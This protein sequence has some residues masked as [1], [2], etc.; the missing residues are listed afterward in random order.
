VPVREKQGE[1]V[2]AVRNQ[3][4]MLSL[5]NQKQLSPKATVSKFCSNPTVMLAISQIRLQE[6]RQGK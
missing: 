5:L 6:D 3:M 1:M 4:P 2:V